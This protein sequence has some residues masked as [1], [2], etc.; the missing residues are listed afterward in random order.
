YSCSCSHLMIVANLDIVRITIN[1]L[2]T[3]APLIINANGMLTSP[4]AFQSMEPVTWWEPQIVQA[5][6]QVYVFELSR[7]SP[8]HIVRES[9]RSSRQI[10]IAGAT[11]RERLDHCR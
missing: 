2:K 8:G 3:N 6:R 1:K 10:Q 11:V 4:I 5:R 7:S 9:T